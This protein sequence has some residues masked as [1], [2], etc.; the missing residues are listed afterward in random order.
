GDVCQYDIDECVSNPCMNNGTCHNYNGGFHCQC[1]TDYYG[2]RCEYSP[3]DC[4]RLQQ[5]NLSL[6]CAD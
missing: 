1:P 3:A 5:K 4:Q 2:K 6:K